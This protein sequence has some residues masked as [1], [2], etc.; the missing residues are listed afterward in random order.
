MIALLCAVKTEAEQLLGSIGEMRSATLGSKL[1]IEGKLNN[2]QI[3]LCVGGIGK[4]NAAHAATLMITR[5][6]PEAIVVFGIGGAYPSSGAGVGDIAIA[7]KEIAGDEGVLTRE[8]FRDTEYMGIPLVK[9][10]ASMFYT[11]YPASEQMIDQSLQSLEAHRKS[12]G[13]TL[14]VGSFVTL[15]TCTGTHARARELEERYQ[16]LCENMEGAAV[17]QVAELH[18]VPWLE[19][20]GISNIVEDRDLIKWDILQAAEAAQLAIKR[21]VEGWNR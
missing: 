14:H 18:G 19:V 16:G 5:F 10:A 20:R 3:L 21:I 1:L 2:Q 12:D 15:S 9:T 13:S 11:T 6:N 17:A 8:G 7:K 4:V